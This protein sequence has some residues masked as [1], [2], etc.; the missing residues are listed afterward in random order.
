MPKWNSIAIGVWVS[1]SVT[2]CGVQLAHGAA[3]C[4]M[5]V[6]SVGRLTFMFVEAS[7]KFI[8]YLGN[9]LR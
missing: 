3:Q 7:L 4:E 6:C 9:D 5:W 2:F 1:V 8:C